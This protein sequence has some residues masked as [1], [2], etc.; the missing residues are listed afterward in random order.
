MAPAVPTHARL[1]TDRGRHWLK[2]IEQWQA[3]N[4]TQTQYC[5]DQNLSIGAF[6]WW[7]RRLRD[8]PG[9]NARQQPPAIKPRT[10]FA[11]ISS[12]LISKPNMAYPYEIVLP[13][14]KQLRL[15]KDFDVDAVSTL[16]SLLEP[17]C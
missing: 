8:V 5:Q 11:E 1:L 4:T 15:R 17:S 3:S 12:H 16:L 7:R 13:N 9:V 2:H 6:G 14:Q 10:R